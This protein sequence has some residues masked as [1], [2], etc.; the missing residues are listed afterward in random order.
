M[1]LRQPR[2]TP[3][4]IY[5]LTADAD[6]LGRTINGLP[7]IDDL[8]TTQALEETI[9]QWASDVEDVSIYI[10]SHGGNKTF[11]IDET[12]ILEAQQLKQW[13]DTLQTKIS[14]RITVIL[15][16][17]FSGSFVPA[18]AGNNQKRYVIS[19]TSKNQLAIISNRGTNSFSYFFWDEVVFTGA[20]REAYRKARQ[21]MARNIID[22]SPQKAVLDSNGDGVESS[23][24][25]DAVK[26]YC[27]GQ[28]N[29]LAGLAPEIISLSPTEDLNAQLEVILTVKVIASNP[30]TN[31][32]VTIQRPDYIFPKATAINGLPQVDLSCMGDTC[33]GVYD[34]FNV[35]GIYRLSFYVEDSTGEVSLPRTIELKQTGA[36]TLASNADII[37]QPRN[38]LLSI[39]DVDVAGLHFW[40]EL[41]DQG[42]FNFILTDFY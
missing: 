25:Y 37:Y 12:T 41:R 3:E 40:V 36:D 33:Q 27:F 17:C 2:F 4:N 24:D 34:N 10:V 38:G 19:S 35:N 14:G 5:Y 26:D 8:A 30:L 7:V 23:Q 31:A 28:C 18:L 39:Q 20:L 42:D 15:D 32:W 11:L 13:L 1:G 9:T 29:K 21:A 22:G 16:A 6:D